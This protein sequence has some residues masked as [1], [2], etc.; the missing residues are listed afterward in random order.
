MSDISTVRWRAY[1]TPAPNSSLADPI[2]VRWG[3]IPSQ[4]QRAR[5]SLSLCRTTGSYQD[6]LEQ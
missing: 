6:G 5:Y 4:Q 1:I 2:T 3:R